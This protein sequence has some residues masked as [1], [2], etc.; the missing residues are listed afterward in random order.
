V[1]IGLLGGTFNPPHVAHLVCAAEAY[2]QLGLDRVL[3]V[4]TA[5]PPHKEVPDDPG[6]ELRARMCELAV[7][8]DDRLAVS[9]IEVERPGPSYTVDTLKTLHERSP[10]DDLTF[11]VGGDMAHSLP[12]WHDPE[13]ILRLAR[14][15]VAERAEVRRADIAERL[16]GLARADQVAFF[17]MPRIDVASSDLRRRVAAGRSIRYLVSDAVASYIEREG[18]YR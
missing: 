15:G 3:L 8:G 12:T 1:K 14:V 7:E 6:P 13:G 2:D 9:R 18:L 11:I 5:R 4:P 10:E 17:D 16:A